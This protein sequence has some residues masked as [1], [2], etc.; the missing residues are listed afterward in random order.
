MSDRQRAL[1]LLKRIEREQL[2]AS[3][4]LLDENG[5]VRTVVLGVLRWRRRLDWIIATLAKRS[6]LKLDRDVVD[7]LRIG[8]YQL[9]YMDVAPHAAVSETVDLATPRARGFVNAI[10]RSAQRGAPEPDDLS[11]RTA[12]PPW[13]IDRWTTR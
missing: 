12:H 5:F 6:I 8:L 1:Q 9:L 4:L 2:Y 7:I 3:L 11:T 10:L 13:L